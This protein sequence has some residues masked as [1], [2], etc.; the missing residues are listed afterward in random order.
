VTVSRRIIM[1]KARHHPSSALRH[2]YLASVIH[3]GLNKHGGRLTRRALTACRHVVSG[4]VSSPYRGSSHLSLALL[5]SLS[6]AREYLA[7]RD[8]PRS[9]RPASTC[10]VLLRC[11][12]VGFLL[13]R[14]GLSPSMVA[15]SRAVLLKYQ[16]SKHRSYNPRKTSLSGL[17]YS[18]F[19]RR[20]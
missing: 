12:I 20:Y 5:G 6:V 19:A 8:G 9:F 14:T 1:Q 2:T 7:L 4:S 18:A 17:G 11:R 16:P 15:L 13:S 10:R 3:G